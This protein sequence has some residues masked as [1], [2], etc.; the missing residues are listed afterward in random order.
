MDVLANFNRALNR[1]GVSMVK[2]NVIVICGPT[3]TGK[4]ITAIEIAKVF[5][6]EI[7]SADSMQIYR[8]MDI[9]T[10]KPTDYEQS[11]A[12][13]HMIDIINPDE[14]FDASKY[15]EMAREVI[16]K[17]HKKGVVPI[18]AGGTGLYIKAL[19]HG[20]FRL[21]QNILDTRGT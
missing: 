10:A 11:I 4:T 15:A 21:S 17:L 1:T 12:S 19:L 8:H 6:G 7:I 5:N 18:V 20:L 9:G 13:H 3:G 14:S 16:M 2:P